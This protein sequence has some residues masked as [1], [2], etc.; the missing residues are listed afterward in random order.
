MKKNISL[1]IKIIVCV[2]VLFFVI[3]SS[4]VF[5]NTLD[6]ERSIKKEVLNASGIIADVVHS[7]INYTMSTGNNDVIT[8]QMG[9][10]KQ[11]MRGGEIF[12]FSPNKTIAFA[13]EQQTVK[14]GIAR[15]IK[16]PELTAA[17]D[18][19]L[20]NAKL[21]ELAYEE[22]V[23]GKP[24]LTILRPISNQERCHQCH[25]A[26]TAILGGLMVRQ[27]LGTM[28]SS[29]RN[30]Q[31]KNILTGL[32]GCLITLLILYYVI[33]RLVIGPINRII[34]GLHNG[35][36]Q[37]LAS[38]DAVAAA[39]QTLAEGS[40]EQAA[41]IEETSASLEEMSSMTQQNAENA[42]HVDRLLKEAQSAVSRA[43]KDMAGLTQSMAKISQASEET[44]KIIKTIDGI[45]FQ[46]NLLALNAAVEA[47][48]AGDAGAGFSV[49]ANEVRNLS[50]RAA[51][52]AKD[53]AS[54]IDE[55][56]QRV[57]EGV[58]LVQRTDRDFAEVSDCTTKACELAS[59]IMVASQEQAQG[60]DQISAAV[61]EMDKVV[62]A[63]AA[64]AE[65][66]AAASE[67]LNQLAEGLTGT[68][69]ELVEIVGGNTEGENNHPSTVRRASY[70]EVRG[71]V[72]APR[73]MGKKLPPPKRDKQ[74]NGKVP[75]LVFPLTH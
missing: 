8:Q 42:G 50:V 37:L 3:L 65:E 38:S 53:T 63:N 71:A 4:I 44:S 21:P 33:A 19:L 22:M 75:E 24:Y 62:Q 58:D 69:E 17:I 20:Q 35:S 31:L 34:H 66:S 10:L 1:Q 49:V 72:I 2:F 54:L 51:Q 52:A 57:Q 9:G 67:E 41:G 55:T 28:Y 46:T 36:E 56:L 48:R 30:L 43:N 16:S 40:T 26:G 5:L 12:V 29:I 45:A 11:S 18:L 15:Q 60:I 74:N 7:D 25:P 32:A 27:S 61:L 14:T 70:V 68:V 23:D 13:S 47:A 59:N 6:Q 73:G 39:S 64:G